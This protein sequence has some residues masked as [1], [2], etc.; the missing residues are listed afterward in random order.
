MTNKNTLNQMSS[1]EFA[2]WIY[3]NIIKKAWIGTD[4]LTVWLDKEV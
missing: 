3:F 2:E 1:K 4:A